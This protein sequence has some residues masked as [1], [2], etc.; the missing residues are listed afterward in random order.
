MSVNYV[1]IGDLSQ[2]SAVAGTE[3]IVVSDTEYITPAQIGS[4]YLPLSG[5]TMTGAIT[6]DTTTQ[7]ATDWQA[8]SIRTKYV[9]FSNSPNQTSVGTAGWYRVWYGNSADIQGTSMILYLSKTFNSGGSEAYTFEVSIAGNGAINIT[10]LSGCVQTT[11]HI[12]KVRVVYTYNTTGALYF[13]FYYSG[14]V[15]NNVNVY[16]IAGKGHCQAP[17][18]TSASVSSSVELELQ[19]NAIKTTNSVVAGGSVTGSSFIKSGGTGS[20]YLRADGSVGTITISSSEPT[21]SDGNN[22]DIWIKI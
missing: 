7:Y 4:G 19:K 17:S 16:G 20:Q 13:D 9:R 3:K 2:K 11:Q 10:Q 22:G 8:N 1:D 12:T 15:S 6:P 18:S 21:S 5:G 14:S